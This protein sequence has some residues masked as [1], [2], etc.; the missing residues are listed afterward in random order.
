MGLFDSLLKKE[1][2]PPLVVS[3]ETIVAMADGK[4]ID[5]TS[6]NDPVFA[7]KMMGESTAFTYE[8]NEVTLCAPAN[9]TL[10]VIFPTGHAFGVTMKDG[11]ELLVHC[12]INTVEAKGDGFK[13]LK[14]QGQSVKAG[15]PVV[16]ADLKKLKAKY[17]MPTMLIVTNCAGH[18]VTFIAPCEIKRG[19]KVTE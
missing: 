9:G 19:Q 10:S 7:S 14:K 8:G 12:G 6:V 2:L 11:T 15:E 4:L 16:K 3:D 1:T 13:V 5:V 17:D 18:P